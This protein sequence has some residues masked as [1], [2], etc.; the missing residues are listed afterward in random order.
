MHI[1]INSYD[2]IDSDKRAIGFASIVLMDYG[3]SKLI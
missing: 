3:M 2:T 1:L